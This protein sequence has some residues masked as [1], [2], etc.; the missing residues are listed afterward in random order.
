LELIEEIYGTIGDTDRWST[1]SRRLAD[2]THGAA[3]IFAQGISSPTFE[4]Y[5]YGY[6]T[7]YIDSYLKYYG[8]L[9]WFVPYVMAR[10]MGTVVPC[11]DLLPRSE[12]KRTEFVTD[13]ALP[14]GFQH[15][16]MSVINMETDHG[17]YLSVARGRDTESYAEEELRFLSATVPHI[18]RA[19]SLDLKLA[20]HEKTGRF[21]NEVFSQLGYAAFSLSR[22]GAVVEMNDRAQ[23]LTETWQS[24][25][26][27]DGRL[28]LSDASSTEWLLRSVRGVADSLIGTTL[29]I[30]EGRTALHITLVPQPRI[31]GFG[32]ANRPG[33]LLLVKD[34][35]GE[36]PAAGA[37][38][39]AFHLTPAETRLLQALAGGKSVANFCDE[40]GLSRNTVKTQLQ[41]LFA[42]TGT[43]RQAELVRL[44]LGGTLPDSQAR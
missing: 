20:R 19:I 32:S 9:N 38:R 25:Q 21:T 33:V 16:A 12:F 27:R 3:A 22:N 2:M 11:T 29:R 17:V 28:Q 34:K 44:V 43:S 15:F 1:I 24:F 42:K 39:S 41:S 14:Q 23:A 13:W 36:I 37:L 35:A 26:L 5:S 8:R 7:P 10:P 4:Q 6:G 31:N 40:A 30:G 18:R